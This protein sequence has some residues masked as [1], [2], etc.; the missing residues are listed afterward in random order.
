MGVQ[1]HSGLSSQKSLSKALD[2]DC[3]KEPTSTIFVRQH[4]IKKLAFPLSF[5]YSFITIKDFFLPLLLSFQNQ[6][7]TPG[8]IPFSLQI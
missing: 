6:C 5:C 4:F 7:A 3:I 1:S 2:K 8:L